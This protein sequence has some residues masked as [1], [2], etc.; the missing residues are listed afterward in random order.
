MQRTLQPPPWQNWAGNVHCQ[1]SHCAFPVTLE[2]VQSELKRCAEEAERLRIVGRGHALTPLNFSDENHMSLARFTG[3]ESVDKPRKRAWVRAGTRMGRL[4]QALAQ[5]GLAM[6]IH[7]D[8]DQQTIGGAFA[9]GML[10]SANGLA[11]LSS[12][13]TGYRIVLPNGAAHSVTAADGE[14]FDAGRLSLGVLGV[15]THVEI[16]CRTPYR[17]DT[18]REMA[19]FTDVIAKLERLRRAHRHLTVYWYPRSGDALLLTRNITR[20]AATP[21][22]NRRRVQ[23]FLT[24]NLIGLG[25]DHATRVAP[26]LAPV[27]QRINRLSGRGRPWITDAHAAYGRIRWA[28]QVESEYAIPVED[29]PKALMQLDALIRKQAFKVALPITVRFA[30]AE[31]AWLSPAY[32]REVALIGIRAPDQASHQEYFSAL[33]SV[34]DRFSARPHW[35]KLHDKTA[36]QLRLLYPRFDDFVALRSRVDPRGMLMNRYLDRLLGVAS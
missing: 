26:A 4:G 27:A 3:V 36:D 20:G 12:L 24:D 5:R 14:N 2:E 15:V 23:D 8:H 31:Q 21:L 25:L 7:S 13:V 28:K 11:S 19:R 33:W 16:Q 32:Q 9:G 1:P 6:D 35:G 17:L 22:S 10:N 29:A 30:P 34:L 18:R